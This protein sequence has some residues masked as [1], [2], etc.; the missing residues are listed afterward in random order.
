[1]AEMP[2]AKVEFGRVGPAGS[3]GLMKAIVQ[4]NYVEPEARF[5]IYSNRVGTS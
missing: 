2:A 3:G 5:P 4:D 1:M